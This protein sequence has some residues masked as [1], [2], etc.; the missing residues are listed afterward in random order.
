[1][2]VKE[3]LESLRGKRIAVIGVGV[4]NTPLIELLCRAGLDVT[5]RDR[6]AREDFGGE[7]GRL[8]ALGTKFRLGPGYMDELTEDVIYK[9]PGLRPDTQ[10]LRAAR[11]R[12]SVISSEMEAFFAVCPCPIIAVTGSDGKTTT[13]TVIAELLN[14]AGFKLHLGGNIGNP[15]LADAEDMDPSDYAVVELSSFQLMTMTQSADVAVITNVTPNHLDYHRDMDEYIEA[16]KN[17]FSHQDRNGLLVINADNAITADFGRQAHGEV[18]SFSR[19]EQQENGC[20]FDGE[21]IWYSENGEKILVI[22]RNEVAL[23][24]LHN[25]EN[26]MAAFCAVVDIVG[27]ESCRRVARHFTG[28]EHRIEPVRTLNGV[29]FFNDSIA[30]SPTRTIAGLESFDRKLILIAGG[31]D[32]HIPYDSLGPAIRRHVK[33]LVLTGAT[34]PKIKAAV[35]AEGGGE[36][37]RII[38]EDDFE[39]AV[40]LAAAGAEPGDVVILSPASASFDK[41]KN[42]A[43]RGN[44]FKQIVNSL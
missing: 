9:T 29:D 11:E 35:L 8:E 2:T 4:S 40:R 41:F 39:K 12:G 15:L 21:D 3:Y 34:S 20:W 22:S 44:K 26:L 10:E 36:L 7:Y 43:E 1:M 37:P 38:E 27:L 24:G 30:S 23:R 17:V 28:V 19:L 6:R 16:K 18:R 13:T 42:F 31:Y 33:L 25:I 32:K 14:E 5:A